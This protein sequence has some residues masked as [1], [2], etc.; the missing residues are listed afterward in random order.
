MM[1]DALALISCSL[2]LCFGLRGRT[3][4]QRARRSQ[5]YRRTWQQGIV[6]GFTTA[7]LSVAIA[8]TLLSACEAAVWSRLKSLVTLV[9]GLGVVNFVRA[10]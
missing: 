8:P 1:L 9:L 2:W 10:N 4:R 5:A 6:S 7:C 3:C